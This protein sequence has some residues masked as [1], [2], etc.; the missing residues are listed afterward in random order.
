MCQALVNLGARKLVI[1]NVGPL[2]CIPYRM[3]VS[4]TTKGQC[5]QSDNSLVMS[6]NS[7]LKSLVDELNGKYPNAKFILANSFNVVSQ[8]ISNP[9]GF[10]NT[11]I[12]SSRPS[13]PPPSLNV[14]HCHDIDF[15]CRIRNEGSSVLRCADRL[16][17]WIISLLPRGPLL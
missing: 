15:L 2:G 1:S 5:V 7:A 12:T 16:P 8:I 10:G 9:G 6:F 11:T 4:S 14:K 17:P 3:A 13:I